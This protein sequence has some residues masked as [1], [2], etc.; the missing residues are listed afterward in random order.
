[1]QIC[2]K[3]HCNQS[4]KSHRFSIW[5]SSFLAYLFRKWCAG[6]MGEV[7]EE[8]ARERERGKKDNKRQVWQWGGYKKHSRK[9]ALILYSELNSFFLLDLNLKIH[10]MI[11]IVQ[12]CET[13]SAKAFRLFFDEQQVEDG[14]KESDETEGWTRRLVS[15]AATPLQSNVQEENHCNFFF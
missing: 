13:S 6:A 5:A 9:N 4:C 11:K 10:A 14:E 12:Q 8:I 2:V 1:M 15:S 7:W 3:L